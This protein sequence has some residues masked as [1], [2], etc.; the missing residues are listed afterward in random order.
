VLLAF[1]TALALSGTPGTGRVLSGRV[2]APDAQPVAGAQIVLLA[3]AGE[4]PL[5]R[6]RLAEVQS[7]P[8]GRF[9]LR[10]SDESKA[11]LFLR[12]EGAGVRVL[13]LEPGSGARAL[14]DLALVGPAWLSGR[15]TFVDGHPA[16]DLELWAVPEDVAMQ[17]DALVACVERAFEHELAGAGLFTTRVRTD[18]DGRFR[19]AGLRA[20]HYMLRCPRPAV[21][22]EPRSGYYQATTENIA[23]AVESP[24]LRVRALDRSGRELVGA[25]VRLLELNEAGAGRYQPGLMWNETIGGPLACASFDVQQE[26]AYGVRIEAKGFAV[27]EDLV[28]LAQKEYEQVRE[29]RLEPAREPGRVRIV[30]KPVPGVAPGAFEVDL[31]SPLYLAPDPEA[32]P[33]KLD[34]K[35]WLPPLPPG[36][37]FFALRFKDDASAL[38]WY[39]P[40]ETKEVLELASKAECEV[41]VPLEAGGRFELQLS[42]AALAQVELRVEGLEGQPACGL[43][44]AEVPEKPARGL[45]L[46]A[47]G[48]YTIRAG[49]P[50]CRDLAAEV[51]LEAGKTTR[52]ELALLPR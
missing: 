23:L 34:E 48:R 4:K 28:L 8:D 21:V 49:A 47:A 11:E 44:F 41:L 17:P 5:P 39:L 46:L 35:G 31:V 45:D 12:G 43:R 13:T 42:G 19:L 30:L 20:G 22:L 16:P 50:R 7:G 52:L 6:K 27:L 3:P 18:L 14:G 32:E 51:L 37:Y 10:T 26:S 24:R 9:E 2:L 25:R 40:A 1:V 36:Q 33:L 15:A 38:N 29:Y